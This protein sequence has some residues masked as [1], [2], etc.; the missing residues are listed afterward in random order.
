MKKMILSTFVAFASIYGCHAMAGDEGFT[1][2]IVGVDL[3]QQTFFVGITP[4]STTSPCAQKGE[5]KW[6]LADPGA[7]EAISVL[8]SARAMGKKI[9]VG[10]S[11]ACVAGEAT[12]T[13]LYIEQ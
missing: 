11:S 1:I 9:R 8:L 5:L 7:K 12:G 10:V 2:T 6:N 13:Y 4:A 3:A